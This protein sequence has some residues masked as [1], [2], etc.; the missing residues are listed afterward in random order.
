[1]ISS[2][3]P[4]PRQITDL[5]DDRAGAAPARLLIA[6]PSTGK[7]EM[8]TALAAVRLD[9]DLTSFDL[10]HDLVATV[11][12]KPYDCVLIDLALPGLD[13]DAL[14]REVR[15]FGLDTPIIIVGDQADLAPSLRWIEAG[16]ANTISRDDLHN[17]RLATCLYNVLRHS[18]TARR[19][20]RAEHDLAQ[21]AEKDPLTQLPN[22]TLF[23][24]RLQHAVHL[25]GRTGK[26]LGM[27]LVDLNGFSKINQAFGNLTGDRLLELT[28]VRLRDALRNSDVIA[29][30][31][32]DEFAIML[33]TS[34]TLAGAVTTATRLLDTMS[35][36]FQVEGHEFV[37]GASIGVALY[38]AH[39]KTAE[40][41]FR[42]AEIAMRAAKKANTGFVIYAGD[43]N[44]EGTQQSDQL[45]L[46]H[47]LRHALEH[48][49]FELFY[50][51][52]VAM[53]RRQVCGVEAL[54]RWRHP[55]LGMVFP[56][57]FI[58]LAE[59][60]GIIEP[61]TRWVLNA[62][63]EQCSIWVAEGRDLPI[64]VNLSA[65]TLHNLE[66]P[67]T[68]QAL[69]AKWQVSPDRLVLEIT[70]SAIISDVVRASE[71][72]TRLHDMGVR[73][74]IDDFGTGYTSLSYIRK[75]PVSELKVDKSFV[76]NM[77]RVPDD[78]VIVRTLVELGHNLGLLVV[79][80]GVEDRETYELLAGL[81]CNVAQGYLMSRAVDVATLNQWLD[82]SIWGRQLPAQVSA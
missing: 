10:T 81:G 72:L 3:P 23:F 36:P 65:L 62:A 5:L 42:G 21:R 58:P 46:A 49:E 37:I 33:A 43:D 63:L 39:G 66:F 64:S 73:I 9:L 24:D 14:L 26:Q 80:E 74:S 20:A 17:E 53:M 6:E 55:R 29:R 1:M 60:T 15:A 19:L 51:P 28:S 57:V 35:R 50:Q 41:L 67:A 61:L 48:N 11:A 40:T 59:Q 76:M 34:A 78:A 38:P 45:A 2:H 22:R 18:R 27:L 16:A 75:L 31:G 71:T 52:K 25:G 44:A 77:R 4:L 13:I 82:T 54:L 70:E 12:G 69:L 30:V 68:V 56:D 79:A 7:R 47:D 8:F 32:D